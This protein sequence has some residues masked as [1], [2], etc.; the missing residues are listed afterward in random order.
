MK[1][2]NVLM[3]LSGSSEQG[4]LTIPAITSPRFA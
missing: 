3:A 1:G 2:I 4:F